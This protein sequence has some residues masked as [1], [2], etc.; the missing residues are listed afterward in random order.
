M[1]NEHGFGFASAAVFFGG[2]GEAEYLG[3]GPE[4][5]NDAACVE[6]TDDGV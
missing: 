5:E 3:S 1:F 2:S 4:D 6:S